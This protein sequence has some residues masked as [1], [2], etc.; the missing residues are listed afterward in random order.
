MTVEVT[1]PSGESY[2]G[3]LEKIDDFTVE[4]TD[5]QGQYRSFLRDGDVPKVELHDPLKT[6]YDMLTKYKD[7]DIHNLTAYLV[8]L[9]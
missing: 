4:L 8:T 6:H 5:S 1:L 7:T 2:S 3:K 9:K